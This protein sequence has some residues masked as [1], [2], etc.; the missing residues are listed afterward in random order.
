MSSGLEDTSYQTKSSEWDLL[1]KK[2]KNDR[3]Q[4][5]QQVFL[6]SAHCHR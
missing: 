3:P 4:M 1:I 6:Q 5:I 2:F